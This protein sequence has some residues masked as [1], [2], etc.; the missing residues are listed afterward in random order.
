MA[1]KLP[2]PLKRFLS[3]KFFFLADF[4]LFIFFIILLNRGKRQMSRKKIVDSLRPLT[5]DELS[6]NGRESEKKRKYKTNKQKIV[7]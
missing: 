2:G 5:A 4:V 7:L 6:G 1:P 3:F